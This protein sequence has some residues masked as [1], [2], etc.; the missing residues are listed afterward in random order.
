MRGI[1][2]KIYCSECLLYLALLC[3]PVL[4][5]YITNYSS[6]LMCIFWLIATTF[7][8]HRRH[9]AWLRIQWNN[10]STQGW[11]ASVPQKALPS[12]RQWQP[13][14]C[15]TNRSSDPAW[16][17]SSRR[18]RPFFS[19]NLKLHRPLL[20]TQRLQMPDMS[21]ST[22]MYVKKKRA[23]VRRMSWRVR[24]FVFT[25]STAVALL[26]WRTGLCGSAEWC[27]LVAFRSP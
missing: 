1:W 12:L 13:S 17:S 23:L 21:S 6:C 8:G 2:F 10:V 15:S 20:L 9:L 25:E 11:R 26:S 4:S 16:A 14:A 18:S 7:C 22:R 19:R 24:C 5:F 3:V 27:A